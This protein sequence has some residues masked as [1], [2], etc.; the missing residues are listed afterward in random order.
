[1]NKVDRALFFHKYLLKYHRISSII[2]NC[3]LDR[4]DYSFDGILRRVKFEERVLAYGED[5]MQADVRRLK[6]L[7]QAL[8]DECVELVVTPTTQVTASHYLPPK[9]PYKLYDNATTL[10]REL[11][12]L[13]KNFTNQLRDRQKQKFATKITN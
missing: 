3:F 13:E 6:E 9:N 5:R 12:L 1:M 4:V 11:T 8:M 10:C 2:L 7:N